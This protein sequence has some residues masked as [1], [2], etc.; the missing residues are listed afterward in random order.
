MLLGAIGA[1]GGSCFLGVDGSLWMGRDKIKQLPL[2]VTS[3]FGFNIGDGFI[4]FQ[5]D[6]KNIT[7]E[8]PKDIYTPY[9]IF[10][11]YGTDIL[12]KINPFTMGFLGMAWFVILLF[13]AYI[14]K[15][16]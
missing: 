3:T 9:L 7:V 8:L 2:P 16:S 6:A 5:I 13:V 14:K 11:G 15:N 10:M 4:C 1:S 12:S